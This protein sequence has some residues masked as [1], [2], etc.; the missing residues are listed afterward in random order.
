MMRRISC[1]LMV[2]MLAGCAAKPP[3]P[4]PPPPEPPPAPAKPV[5]IVMD[6]GDKA[7]VQGALR[8]AQ[9]KPIDQVVGWANPLSGKRGA[10]K[11]LRDGYDGQN[12]PC[13][14]FHSVV[15]LEEMFLH[16]T[17]FLCRLPNGTWDIVEMRD[18]PLYRHQS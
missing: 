5:D 17:G 7:A 14:E 16:S 9:T 15:V 11:I 13:R 18:Y 6:D 4:P 12:R 1:F 2:L 3:P 10:V 8:Q